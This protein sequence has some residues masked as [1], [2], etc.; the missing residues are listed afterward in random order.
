MKGFPMRTAVSKVVLALALA[1]GPAVVGLAAPA[2][3]QGVLP[4]PQITV[5]PIPQPVP[6]QS[7]PAPAPVLPLPKPLP[8]VPKLPTV[9]AVPG[10]PTLPGAPGPAA[11][12]AA[13]LAPPAGSSGFLPFGRYIDDG[14]G[15]W[16][17]PLPVITVPHYNLPAEQPYDDSGYNTYRGT[18]LDDHNHLVR[19][20]SPAV[21][22]GA[23]AQA[24][25]AV[26]SHLLLDGLALLVVTAAGAAVVSARKRGLL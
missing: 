8:Q 4:G 26:A 24:A 17:P 15:R 2:L 25:H 22:R 12:P 16:L 13:P 20:Q 1:G 3:A 10:L 7:S 14:L 19:A 6:T 9:P 18:P 5:P 11:K 23:V 21:R